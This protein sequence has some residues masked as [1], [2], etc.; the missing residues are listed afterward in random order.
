MFQVFRPT[1]KGPPD[2][3]PLR[4]ADSEQVA[5]VMQE[6]A[7]VWAEI[8]TSLANQV[9]VLSF[10]AATV[11][12]LVSAAAQLWTTAFL[13]TGLLFLLAVPAVCFLALAIYLGEQIRLMRAGLFLNRLEESVNGWASQSRDAVT[14]GRGDSGD[15]LIWEH[16]SSI[17]QRAGD[18]DLHNRWAIVL[19]FALLGAASSVAGYL[20][21]HTAPELSELWAV[22][23]FIGS[24]V[25]ATLWLAWLARLA[26][27]ADAY[28][29]EY[30]A[31]DRQP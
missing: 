18:V 31:G 10:G 25:L 8:H 28:R 30:A 15:V 14:P 21:L 23:A 11:G 9:S 22:L 26:S 1:I 7:A 13:V 16:W 3:S 29:R 24:V 27:Y 17:K 4:L 5:L 20:R 19:V 6:Y 2:R 12:L